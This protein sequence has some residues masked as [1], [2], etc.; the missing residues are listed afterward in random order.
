MALC[1]TLAQVSMLDAKA[2][3]FVQTLWH[4]VADV[5]ALSGPF[6]VVVVVLMVCELVIVRL[7]ALNQARPYVLI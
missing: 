2:A 5:E 1:Q 7:V 3:S 6:V 4:D